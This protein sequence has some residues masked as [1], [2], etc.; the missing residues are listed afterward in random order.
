MALC[1]GAP[2]RE[3]PAL[4]SATID[5]YLLFSTP[6]PI[7]PGVNLQEVVDAVHPGRNFRLV[8]LV[9]TNNQIMSVHREPAVVCTSRSCLDPRGNGTGTG[10][11]RVCVTALR[12]A[13]KPCWSARPRAHTSLRAAHRVREAAKSL[14]FAFSI[15]KFSHVQQLQHPDGMMNALNHL[16]MLSS[17]LGALLSG[18]A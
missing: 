2:G 4:T 13:P 9:H 8:L 15:T 1:R 3:R 14:T 18:F 16:S 5:I 7:S 12:G 6:I 10:R 17:Q 11:P